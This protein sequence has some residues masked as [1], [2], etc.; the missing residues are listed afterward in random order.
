MVV[1][2]FC[3]AFLCLVREDP[4]RHSRSYEQYG[5]AKG[6]EIYQDLCSLQAVNAVEVGLYCYLLQIC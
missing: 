3:M 2:R 4:I 5:D 1:I 6:E